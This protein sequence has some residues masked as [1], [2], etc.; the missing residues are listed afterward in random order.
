MEIPLSAGGGSVVVRS[1]HRGDAASLVRHADDREVWRNLRDRF[2]SPY[3]EGDA[4]RWLRVASREDPGMNFAIAVDGEAVGGIGLGAQP[5]VF[6]R[7]V[8]IGYWLGRPY[9]GRGIMT[10]AVRAVTAYGFATLDVGRIFAGVF[11]WNPA[12][13]RV[14]E[15]AGYTF[16][17]RLRR[18]VTKDGH[19]L[20][21]LMYA[22]TR[23]DA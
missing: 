17:A 11:D 15:K 16:E 6:R 13:A 4:K 21:R 10:E 9:W 22:V 14:L 1:W 7:S 5:D 2:P 20:D 8:E 3:T 19:T 18:D 12:S 23:E